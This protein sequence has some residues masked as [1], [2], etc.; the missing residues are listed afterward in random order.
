MFN[1]CKCNKEKWDLNKKMTENAFCW[2]KFYTFARNIYD[3]EKR[4]DSNRADSRGALFFM[5]KDEIL[6]LLDNY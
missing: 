3:D 4:F 2:R 5:Q 1:V 6:P